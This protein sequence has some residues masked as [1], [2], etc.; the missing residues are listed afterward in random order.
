MIDFFEHLRQKPV[1]V[2]KQI[3]FLFSFFVVGI[4]VVVWWTVWYPDMRDTSTR[5]AVASEKTPGPFSAFFSNMSAGVD[6]ISDQVNSLK[7]GTKEV[8][9]AEPI[10]Y[11]APTSTPSTSS[12]IIR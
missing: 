6:V 1:R 4:I 5:Q 9:T 2:R 3:A 8:F 7:D 12:V 11:V 10:Y